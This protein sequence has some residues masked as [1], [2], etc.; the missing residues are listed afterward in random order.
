MRIRDWS[1]DVCSS[2]LKAQGPV[3]ATDVR[4]QQRIDP[5]RQSRLRRLRQKQ[6][7]TR[8]ISGRDAV[9]IALRVVVHAADALVEAEGAGRDLG[10]GFDVSTRE[11]ARCRG[12]EWC[13]TGSAR[14]EPLLERK[15]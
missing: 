1:S 3:A 14:S 13:S 7:H 2:D 12:Q 4:E 15:K 10:V 8:D 9:V 6:P 11:E 5:L